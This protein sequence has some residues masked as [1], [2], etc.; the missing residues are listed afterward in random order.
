MVPPIMQKST[1]S[2]DTVSQVGAVKSGRVTKVRKS[3]PKS[4]EGPIISMER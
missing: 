1:Q 4:M 2:M 3:P